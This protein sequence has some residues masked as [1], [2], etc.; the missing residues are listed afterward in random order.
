MA[1]DFK[2][3]I[4]AIARI[5]AVPTILD[6]VCRATGMGF[7][8][9]ARVTEDRWVACSVKDDIGFGLMPGGELEIETTF[10]HQIRQSGLPIVIDH[11]EID[12]V[13]AGH[14][15]P[16]KYGLQSYISV[17]IIMRG[18]RFFGTL[19]AIDP[20]PA[21]VNRAEI[22]GMF[23]LF[24]DLIAQHLDAHER[25]TNS[26]NLLHEAHRTAELRDQFIAVLGH[27]LRNPLGAITSGVSLLE[28]SNLDA[29]SRTLVSVMGKSTARMT[30]LIEN[31]LD[32]ARGRLGGG[33][34]LTMQ[35]VADM[36][37]TL[38]QVVS[39]LQTRWPD[40]TIDFNCHFK[41]KVR[42]DP[43][44]IAQ[45][46]SNLL[47]NALTYGDATEPVRVGVSQEDGQFE[48]YVANGG[49][50]IA[51]A[52]LARLFQPFQRGM[53]LIE[54]SGETAAADTQGLGLGLYIAS[55]IAKAHKGTLS[56]QSTPLETRFTFRMPA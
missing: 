51:E 36:D 42:C 37:S 14:P 5:E 41:G 24:A 50:P 47:G 32:L 46:F 38:R 7:A 10:C 55:E 9:V 17:P 56:V 40:R 49:K 8:T 33:I 34:S 26:E 3:D 12:S 6:V 35:T 25:A 1:D 16:L 22:L 11:V 19:C 13:Y 29:R 52:S 2:A 23:T 43:A 53:K 28:K 54:T 15:I 21:R 30:E 39:E 4:A 27:D 18:G 44:R 31:V 45:L 20:K 48:L